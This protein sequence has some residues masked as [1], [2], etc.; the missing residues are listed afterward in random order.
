MNKKSL[1]LSLLSVFIWSIIFGYSLVFSVFSNN[2]EVYFNLSD[3]IYTDSLSLNESRIVFKS[4]G[5]LENYSISS[6]CSIF[7]KFLGQDKDL[8]LYEVK[9]LDSKCYSKRISLLDENNEEILSHKFKVLSAYDIYSQILDYDDATLE[10]LLWQLEKQISKFS[11]YYSY[12]K[13]SGIAYNSFLKK[14]RKLEELIY[15]RNIIYDVL[16]KRKQK[17][18][19]PIEGYQIDIAHNRIP[20]AGRPYRSAYTDGI[21]HG[22]DVGSKFGEETIAI[23]D[24]IIVRVVDDFDDSDFNRI[25]YWDNLTYE[26]KLKNLDVLRGN[27]VWLKTSKW[28][29][30]FYSHLEDVYAGIYEGAVVKAGDPIGTTGISGV[31]GTGY[32]DYHLHFAVQKN[33]YNFKRAG[34]YDIE[35]Y[36]KWDW[37]F[38]GKSRSEVIEWTKSIFK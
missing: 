38:K 3:N 22:W 5:D 2:I 35:E 7:S 30:V 11:K 4:S 34:K 37:Y 15:N 29:V 27:Q 28:D 14:N 9:F 23:D 19:V 13:D 31:P 33:P 6:K 18:L 32:K 26:Q 10:K 24:G 12:K 17:Y 16:E 1:I 20:N 36:M 21:H 25:E 8:Y